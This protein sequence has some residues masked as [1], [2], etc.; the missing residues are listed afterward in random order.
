MN[1]FAHAC[2]ALERRSE[3][4]FALG[5]MLPDWTR[6]VGSRI[7][8]IDDPELAA[9]ARFHHAVDDAFHACPAFA[10]R[11]RE[12]VARLRALGLGR[13]PARGAAHVGVELLLDGALAREA[14]RGAGYLAALAVGPEV[15][16]RVRWRDAG[17]AARLDR[18]IDR[19]REHGVPRDYAD[20]EVVAGRVARTLTHR[21]RLR[22]PA[23]R[24]PALVAW[25]REAEPVVRRHAPALLAQTDAGLHGRAGA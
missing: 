11:Q 3:P 9:G 17:G 21:P 4:R 5:A 1:F 6:W 12:A 13:G 7:T 16:H 10:A 2:L 8:A 24:L 23:T 22:V 25:A 15:A 14:H 20:P 19:L 18:V